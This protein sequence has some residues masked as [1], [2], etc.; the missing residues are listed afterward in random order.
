MP[1]GGG[2]AAG[3][4]NA[5][6]ARQTTPVQ[7]PDVKRG[8]PATQ[9]NGKAAPAEKSAAPAEKTVP[10]EKSD[11]APEIPAKATAAPQKR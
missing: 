3:H 11:G 10:A 6:G 5:T 7:A 2:A 4:Q 9:K 8:S 1:L